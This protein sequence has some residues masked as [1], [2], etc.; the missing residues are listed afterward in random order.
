[1]RAVVALL[2]ALTGSAAADDY[3]D[4][5]QAVASAESA[6]DLAPELFG[7]FGYMKQAD[8]DGFGDPILTTGPR[9]TAG[10][11]YRLTGILEGSATRGR[12]RAECD[13]HRA[14]GRVQ[15][16]STYGAVAARAKLLDAALPEAEQILGKLT[17]DVKEKLATEQ[18]LVAMRLRLAELRKLATEARAELAALPAPTETVTGALTAY[19]AADASVEK[20]AA[21]LR[22]LEAFDVS[23]R[24]GYDR[25]LDQDDEAPY[26]A[27]VQVGI[28]LGTLFQGGANSRAAAAR[29]R[30]VR[31]R[32]AAVADTT[33][34][35]LEADL[36]VDT[37]RVTQLATLIADLESQM[38]TIA[39]LGGDDGRRYKQTLWFELVKAKADHAYAQA[40]VASLHQVLGK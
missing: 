5:V 19:Y 3:C 2:V 8:E 6:V 10:V 25:F 22:R 9:L 30:M 21:R 39:R 29:A 31:D 11:R 38:A 1:M 4:H 16:A 32:H 24:A 28:N 18:E 37:L 17:G 7:T 15:G 20:H 23:V 36:A 12:A 27:M 13:R 40:H 14:L 35:T 26:F 33:I 34:A